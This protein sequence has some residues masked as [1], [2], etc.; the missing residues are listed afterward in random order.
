MAYEKLPTAVWELF[1][2]KIITP[3][4]W[5]ISLNEAA[6]VQRRLHKQLDLTNHL[7]FQS[8]QTVAAADVSFSTGSTRLF[9]SVVL[10]SFPR[11]Q[12]LSVYN[13]QM[14]VRFPYIPGYLSFREVPVLSKIFEEITADFDVILCD[15]Q[16]I[17]HPRRFGLAC[18]IG[19]ILDKPSLGCAKSLLTGRYI[20]PSEKKGDYSF[21]YE[22]REK[23]GVVLR[24]RNYVKP[25]IVSPGH[26]ID[27][28]T[29]RRVVLACCSKYRIPDPLR[30]AHSE[31]NR[32]R[33]Q[34]EN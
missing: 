18:H 8:I 6:R 2:M 21:L 26:K 31:V 16:G 14:E 24:S 27:L 19:I 32:Y 33:K 3:H 7:S 22:G 20:E 15:G 30:Y 34:F 10:L 1:V 28:E 5:D 12:L 29:A 4:T 9:G 23:L 17:A 25:L 13:A 11:M